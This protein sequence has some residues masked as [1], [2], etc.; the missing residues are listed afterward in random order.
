MKNELKIYGS[1]ANN[2]LCD[3]IKVLN[4]KKLISLRVQKIITFIPL[5]NCFMLFIWLYNYSKIPSNLK[6]FFKAFFV[7]FV[8]ALPFIIL[9]ILLSKLFTQSE[10]IEVLRTIIG[11]YFTP[12]FMDVG[13]I[14]CQ[15]KYLS[16][17]FNR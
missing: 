14:K 1:L 13:L 6:L 9:N 8:Y 11:V 10:I 16:E 15:E 17:Y 7:A 2:F 4:L 5:V 12:L 3:Y